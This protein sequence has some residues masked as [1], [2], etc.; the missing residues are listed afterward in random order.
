MA[1]EGQ[2]GD[3]RTNLP[4]LDA[5]S[6]QG[7]S[8]GLRLAIPGSG[9]YLCRMPG[10]ADLKRLAAA[11]DAA[12]RQFHAARGRASLN[13]AIRR[14]MR[15]KAELKAAQAERSLASCVEAVEAAVSGQ[16]CPAGV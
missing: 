1:M 12:E 10:R 5:R 2:S 13:A 11:V 7:R 16:A 4:L 6:A 14:M 8:A 9:C 3:F 15:A